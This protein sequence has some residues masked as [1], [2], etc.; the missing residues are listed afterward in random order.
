MSKYLIVLL[1][2]GCFCHAQEIKYPYSIV[3]DGKEAFI[4]PAG[5]DTFWVLKHSQYIN[6]VAN[7]EKLKLSEQQLKLTKQKM[8]IRSEILQ[9][10][11]G[12]IDSVKWGY[13]HY[14]DLWLQTDKKLED[15]EIEASRNW[16][17]FGVGAILGIIA[18]LNI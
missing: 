2:L 4:F 9:L 6:A 16:M 1:M 10:K 18:G 11:T 7:T 13:E 14:K 12:I 15:A 5:T 17:Y 8:E 3:G